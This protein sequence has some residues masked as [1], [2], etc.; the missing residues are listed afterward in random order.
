MSNILIRLYEMSF[1]SLPSFFLFLFFSTLIGCALRP[2]SMLFAIVCYAFCMRLAWCPGVLLLENVQ[3]IRYAPDDSRPIRRASQCH[4]YFD[5]LCSIKT[6]PPIGT[7][8][9]MSIQSWTTSQ[10][11]NTT[12][13]S[14]FVWPFRLIVGS[15]EANRTVC[16]HEIIEFLRGAIFCIVC[17]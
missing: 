6:P 13:P 3:M 17:V 14:D 8:L 1:V 16:S 9:A 12:V 5:V 4:S 10:W 2:F 15:I 11:I 7:V